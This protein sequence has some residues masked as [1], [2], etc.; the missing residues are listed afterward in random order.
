MSLTGD[1]LTLNDKSYS[2]KDKN[3]NDFNLGR[4]LERKKA[5][6]HFH[7]SYSLYNN[8]FKF[9]N[10]PPRSLVLCSVDDYHNTKMFNE[11]NEVH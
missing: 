5:Y 11:I 7:G 8:Y 6:C 3:G 9:E 4:L 2:I 1:E 10:M